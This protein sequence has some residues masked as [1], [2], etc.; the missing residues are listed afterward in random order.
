MLQHSGHRGRSGRVA[1]V[2]TDQLLLLRENQWALAR[3]ARPQ[4]ARCLD[5][6]GHCAAILIHFI[7]L[8]PIV[9]FAAPSSASARL[10]IA[11]ISLRMGAASFARIN[12]R[13]GR[14]R[15]RAAQPDG[16][17]SYKSFPGP[18]AIHARSGFEAYNVHCSRAHSSFITR[19]DLFAFSRNRLARSIV[20]V[21]KSG[22]RVPDK[23]RC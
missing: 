22:W 15:R 23:D 16:I 9:R 12:L 13:M 11:I 2:F 10:R 6:L 21:Q 18:E 17:P 8:M 3:I 7:L 1:F 20:V 5:V 14:D 4:H 19:S